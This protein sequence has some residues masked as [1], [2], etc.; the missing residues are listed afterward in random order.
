MNWTGKLV[1]AAELGMML[2]IVSMV[3]VV[4]AKAA[5]G[6]MVAAEES[7][8]GN[9]PEVRLLSLQIFW[10]DQNGVSVAGE[11]G[12]VRPAIQLPRG[13]GSAGD[14]ITRTLFE[15]RGG[16]SIAGESAALIIVPWSNNA[17]EYYVVSQ[18]GA[19]LPGTNAPRFETIV[20][21]RSSGRSGTVHTLNL[22][23]AAT[24]PRAARAEVGRLVDRGLMGGT[25]YWEA[26]FELIGLHRDEIDSIEAL[27][28][29]L[30]KPPKKWLGLLGE[31]MQA[32]AVAAGV[33]TDPC[34]KL[35][36]L[37]FC[38]NVPKIAGFLASQPRVKER[39]RV[40]LTRSLWHAGDSCGVVVFGKLSSYSVLTFRV[41]TNGKGTLPAGVRYLPPFDLASMPGWN[42]SAGIGPAGSWREGTPPSPAGTIA[43][44]GGSETLDTAT[45]VAAPPGGIAAAT[46][47]TAMTMI[48]IPELSV[49]PRWSTRIWGWSPPRA[50]CDTPQGRRLPRCASRRT[51]TR[52]IG[53]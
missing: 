40:R 34:L 44:I 53:W 35:G 16:G 4:K 13:F 21:T 11:Q 36:P 39:S 51:A 2:S 19:G 27:G 5:W 17:R 7:D 3:S 25:V 22:A 47:S 8:H 9:V 30:I 43:R 31:A 6:G 48:A 49:T 1:T 37:S 10:M 41:R 52:R 14:G 33:A 26:A 50:E 42:G 28:P 45:T 29:G 32:P 12:G 23:R 15:N 18:A 38:L 46:P 20:G 24:L